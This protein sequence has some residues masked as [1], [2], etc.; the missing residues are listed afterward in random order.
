MEFRTYFD[1]FDYLSVSFQTLDQYSKATIT[2]V[3]VAITTSVITT[4]VIKIDLHSFIYLRPFQLASPDS[5]LLRT[6]FIYSLKFLLILSVE[7]ILHLDLIMYFQREV[8]YS[9]LVC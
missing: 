9:R 5:N 1:S 4:M 7:I 2:A 8:I 6:C 3:V